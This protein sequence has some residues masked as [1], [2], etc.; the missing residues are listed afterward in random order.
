[1][2]K[3]RFFPD[4]LW[5]GTMK[6]LLVM[7]LTTFLLLFSVMAIASGSYS[8]NTR[9]DMSV[10]NASIVR[11]LE[12][13]ENK[14]EF[15]FL[16]KTDQLD[17]EKRYFLN[18]K[19]AKIENV[20]DE[21]LDKDLYSYKIMDRII[22]ISKLD[23][24][25]L[26]DGSQK[27]AKV[28]GKI[29][30]PGGQSLPG[31]TV[32][33]KGTSQGT[34]SDADGNYFLNGIPENAVL[35]FSFVGMKTKEIVVGSQTIINVVIEEETVGIEEIIA[36]GYGTQKKRDVIGSVASLS[37]KDISKTAPVTIESTLQGMAAG[38]QVN[39]GAGVPGAPQQVKVRGIR[40]ISSGTDP[41]WIIDGIPVQ[42]GTM[43][44]SFN[45]EINQSILAMFNPNDIES[46]QILK[47]AAA[48]SIY[49]SRGS[50]G[51]ILITTKS[52]KKGLTKV[53]ID[54]KTGISNWVKS[55]VGYA[56]NKEYISIMDLAFKNSG[57][58]QYNV[59]NI[60]AAL[61]GA[62]QTMTREEALATNTNWADEI[63][64]TGSFYEANAA[65]S[66]GTEKGN[67][68]LSLKYRK[69]EGNLKFNS[70]ETFSANAN[71]NYNLLNCFDLGYRL[72][73]SYTDNDRIKS[74]DGKTGAGG[75][76][77]INSNSLPWM[78]VRDAEGLNGYWNSNAYVNALATIDPINA[79]S[80]LKT[81]NIISALTGVL[82]LPVKGLSLRGE[83]GLNFVT[84]R[85]R[86]W[87]SEALLVN[88]AV[89]EEIKFETTIS[90]YNAYFNYDVPINP[91]HILNLVAGVENTRQ[92]SHFMNMKGEGLVGI[93]PEVGT[94]NTL[95]GSTSI[96]G[97]SYLR[98]YFGRANYK[99]FDKYLFGASIRRDGISK[100]TAENRWATF[101]SGSLGWI[102]SEEKFFKV[103]PIS[104]LKLRGSFGQTGNTNI[105]SGITSDSWSVNG[106]VNETLEGNNNTVLQSI[107][108]SDIKWETTNSLD[109]GIDYGLFDNRVNG[110]VAFYRQKV[111]DMLLAVSLPPSAGIRGGNSCWQNIG[112]MRNQGVEFDVNATIISKK[113]FS[114]SAGFNISTNKNKVLAL[115]PES[116]AN[117]VGLLQEGE[118]SV[119]RTIT[120]T[121]LSYGTWYLAEYAGVDSQKGIP[122]IYE[123][124]ALDDGTTKH[125]GNI[126][127][128]TVEN[129]TNNRMILDGKT[130]LPKFLGGFNTNI[131]YKNFDFG[132]V[133]S[134]VT[135][136]YIYNRMFQSAMTPNAGMLV[137]NKKLLTDCW[138]KA[139]DN[140]Y[141]PQVVA[142]NLYYYDN[143]GNPT[144]TGVSYGSDN[145]TPSSQYLEKGDYLKLRN[146]TLGYTLPGKV[147]NK[148]KINNV[149]VYASANNLLTFTKFSGYD[150][151][152]S[153]DQES[154]GAYSTFG[155]MPASRIFMFGLS[156]NF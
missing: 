90:N 88:G 138:T 70:M 89:A 54:I 86:S 94:P 120:K 33:V 47:D 137:L 153:I 118:G 155:S 51:V 26:Q 113:D 9:F 121:G 32:V 67:S 95:S 152:I 35:Q 48:T 61:D 22:V 34:V 74:G 31:V 37:A 100:F 144:T 83:Y 3:N 73:T 96:G 119:I 116:D 82:H 79:Q 50:N 58:D 105:P 53:D 43:D 45:G 141:W 104:L 128:A 107:G 52:G 127:P 57:A 49:G 65:I 106:S 39:S 46:I 4:C 41:L 99:L 63:S 84:N 7:K 38:V 123:V 115:D 44:R 108:N 143:E 27:P 23:D 36:I 76:A 85:A 40:S 110:S 101:I 147:T 149:R 91:D 18:F 2:K 151:E 109:I 42:S 142:G 59:P 71:L 14:T 130:A 11:V 8:Q 117:G 1:M 25:L 129:I 5:S 60:I 16:F 122:L 102:I 145:K 66:Q 81:V 150:P 131:T 111:S 80:N 56:N 72:F 133:W 98:G 13:I 19:E 69:D 140:T 148:Y 136:N 12:E 154:G 139:G 55:D 64:Q 24:A 17:L 75:W 93:F 135:G 20:L 29:T 92:Y 134:F 132:M 87:R 68:Y 103:K 156:V 112:D 125:T 62:T 146:V 21:I 78:K 124:E 10:K 97:E 6:L 126:I 28:S 30:D 15:G 114:W 77:Q